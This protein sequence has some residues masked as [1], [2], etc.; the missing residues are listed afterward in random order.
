MKRNYSAKISYE[1]VLNENR[2]SEM[3]AEIENVDE[4]I[5]KGFVKRFMY[6]FKDNDGSV[7]AHIYRDGDVVRILSNK[8]GSI[9]NYK[10]YI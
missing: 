3:S 2:Q 10:L 6:Y 4:E 9:Y 8:E 1:P 7:I 5:I